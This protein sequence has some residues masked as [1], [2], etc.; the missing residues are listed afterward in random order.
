MDVKT[1]PV[2][3]EWVSL[4]VGLK[5]PANRKAQDRGKRSVAERAHSGHLE[6]MQ[7]DGFYRPRDGAAEHLTFW[8]ATSRGWAPVQAYTW[9]GESQS[10]EPAD[11]TGPRP[12]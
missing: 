4:G 6:V 1:L 7:R 10:W 5:N 12:D 3:E 8:T 2:S 9:N 11:R